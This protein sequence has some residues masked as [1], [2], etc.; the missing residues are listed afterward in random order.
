[1]FLIIVNLQHRVGERRRDRV[2]EVT[3]TEE[4]ERRSLLGGGEGEG[5]VY[6]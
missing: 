5:T 6:T 2:Q 3:P 1:M 4:E